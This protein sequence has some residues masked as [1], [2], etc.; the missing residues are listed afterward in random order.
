MPAGL[1]LG[2][3]GLMPLGGFEDTLRESRRADPR[4]FRKLW[5]RRRLTATGQFEANW[6]NVTRYVE[7]WGSLQQQLD[8]SRLFSIRHSGINLRVRNDEGRFNHHSNLSSMW[9]GYMTRVR[10]LAKVEAGYTDD[11]GILLP[12]DPTQGVFIMNDEIPNSA[13][14]DSVVLNCSSLQAVFDGIKAREIPGMNATMSAGTFFTN[15]KNHTDGAGVS[16]FQQYISSGAWT[17]ATG[18]SNNYIFPTD[19]ALLDK[20]VWDVMEK[21]AEA[22]NRVMLINRT[23]G[24]EFAARTARTTASQWDFYGQGYREPN[25]VQLS[26]MKEAVHKIYASFQL[27]WL[28]ADTS[29]SYVR[30]GTTTAV[31]SSNTAWQVGNRSYDFENLFV[32]NTASAQAIV[33]A[34]QTEFSPAKMEY[35]L[36]AIMAPE[37]ELLDRTSVSYKSYSLENSPLWDVAYWDNF[38]W[39]S[40]GENFNLNSVSAVVIS[41]SLNLNTMV[42]TVQLREA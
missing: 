32:A 13:V 39:A 24:L 3:L 33:D 4:I 23:G 40:D 41:K 12:A 28:A 15:V 36:G 8:D 26:E 34:L 5:I 18:S 16:I 30:A 31:N 22:E 17:I 10:S 1:G 21:L 35:R 6:Q 20:S 14:E 27:K 38:N 19:S 37:L 25:I 42:H 29:T 9:F 7:D 2:G 11:G